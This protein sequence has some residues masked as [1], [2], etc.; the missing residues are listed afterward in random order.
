MKSRVKRVAILAVFFLM[1]ALLAIN[2]HSPV[3]ALAPVHAEVGLQQDP[4][5]LIAAFD[6]A[7]NAHD[8]DGALHLFTDKA[9]VRDGARETYTQ[10]TSNSMNAAAAPTCRIFGDTPSCLYEGPAQIQEWLQQLMLQENIQVQAAGNYQTLAENVTWTLAVSIDA[11]RILHVAPLLETAK[12]SIRDGK[13]QSLVLEL[14]TESTTNLSAAVSKNKQETTNIFTGGFLAGIL[15]LGLILPA[16]AV[17]YISKVRSLFAAVPR[18]ERPW[19]LL[20]GGVSSLFIA[21]LLLMIRNVLAFSI[22]S[23]DI[24]QYLFVVLTGGFILAAMVLMKQV[25]TIPSG[26]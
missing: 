6:A 24:V 26:E 16:A 10:L 9:I 18:L 17:Y 3:H 1:L 12:A 22:P 21:L 23:L 14:T 15:S 7:L 8:V 11:Y 20:L 5:S 4:V 19:F 25:W 2:T 13:I